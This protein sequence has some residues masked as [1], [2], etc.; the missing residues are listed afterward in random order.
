MPKGSFSKKDMR[1]GGG[2]YTGPALLKNSRVAKSDYGGKAATKS[3][4]LLVDFEHLDAED[5]L[6]TETLILSMGR[7]V[8]PADAD[9]DV[10]AEGAFFNSEKGTISDGCAAGFFISSIEDAR[11]SELDSDKGVEDIDGLKVILDRVP[12]GYKGNEDRE[13]Y[14]VKEVVDSLPWEEAPAKKGS[15][16]RPKAAKSE[17]VVDG[18]S[19]DILLA[20]LAAAVEST[21]SGSLKRRDLPT[22]VDKIIRSWPDIG[23][24]RSLINQRAEIVEQLVDEQFLEDFLGEELVYEPD[25]QEVRTTAVTA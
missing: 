5:N 1:Q 10:V 18:P 21:R 15:A 14:F 25:S 8:E 11:G 12:K 19:H 16:P 9:G 2:L 17:G 24:R 13:L 6:A 7:G 4:C 3:T 22:A 23:E 20:V